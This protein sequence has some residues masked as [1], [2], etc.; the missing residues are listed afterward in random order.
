MSADYYL[1]AA[2]DVS[3]SGMMAAMT[4][5][6]FVLTLLLSPSHG[7]V[8]SFVQRHKNSRVFSRDLLLSR[9][10]ALGERATDEALVRS[11][12]WENDR[13]SRTLADALRD[14]YVVRPAA[15]EVTLTRKGRE[16]SAGP[17]PSN[18]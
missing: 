14:G 9:V 17:R 13:V 10:G 4:G 3:I 5:A 8:A 15:G 2:F 7:L 6:L 18:R 11:L 1:A 16:A 12:G